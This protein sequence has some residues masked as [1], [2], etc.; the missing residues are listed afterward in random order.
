MLEV[1][2]K[3]LPMFEFELPTA[4]VLVLVLVGP[5]HKGWIGVVNIWE[6]VPNRDP[7]RDRELGLLERVGAVEEEVEQRGDDGIDRQGDWGTEAGAGPVG[8]EG[9]LIGRYSAKAR[10]MG[11]MDPLLGRVGVAGVDVGVE[12][13]GDVRTAAVVFA[14]DA[15]DG[16]VH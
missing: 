11:A 2:E 8:D 10:E 15:L 5:R 3:A 9:M 1:L 4:L 12:V 13:I 14:E 16:V 6:N 7:E